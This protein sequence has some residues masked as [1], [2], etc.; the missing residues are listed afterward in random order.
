MMKYLPLLIVAAAS[1]AR[2]SSIFTTFAGG[3]RFTGNMFDVSVGSSALLVTGLDVN[4]DTG[5]VT[6]NVYTKAGTYVGSDTNSAAWTLDSSTTVT[7][8]GTNNETFV[9]V[10]PFLLAANAV[11]GMYVTVDSN[12]NAPPYMYYT[13]GNNTYSNADLT[14]TAGE[15][16]GGLFGSLATT[17]SRTWNGQID[18]TVQT[19]T[20]EPSTFGLLGAGLVAFAL[21]KKF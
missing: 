15:G 8:L 18:Y 11:T 14:L 16:L 10:T 3:N 19:A 20:P 4:V 9:S 6:I 21:R 13:N 17:Q 12:T 7:G 1:L 5:S 2:G